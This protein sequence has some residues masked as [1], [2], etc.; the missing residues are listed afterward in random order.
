MLRTFA[1]EMRDEL[2]SADSSHLVSLGTIGTGQCGASGAEYKALHEV[3]DICEMHD[4]NAAATALPGDATNGFATR[5]QQCNDLGKPIFVGEAG[6]VADVGTGGEST[7][8]ID[9]TTLGRRGA[10]FAAKLSAQLAAGMDGYLIWDKLIENSDSSLNLNS[11]RYARRAFR[12]RH[13]GRP[14]RGRDA[15]G[16]PAAVAAA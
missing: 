15:G 2:R 10:F 5:I 1:K 12:R 3:V 7:G 14:G 16:G 11:G 6:I 8:T 4:Y 9:A 13:D